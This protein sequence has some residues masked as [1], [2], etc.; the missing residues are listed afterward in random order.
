MIKNCSAEELFQEIVKV[1]NASPKP[2]EGINAVFQYNLTG[3][4]QATYQ[5]HL[6]AG[7]AWVEKNSSVES[8]CTMQLALDDFKKMLLGK[9]NGTFAFM[10]GKLKI[11]GNIGLALKLEK[12]L[13]E[14][15]FSHLR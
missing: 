4:D 13:R 3:D 7:N 12:L 5:L 15:D 9:R 11:N 1:V 6:S 10:T 8:N 14:Y 2:I